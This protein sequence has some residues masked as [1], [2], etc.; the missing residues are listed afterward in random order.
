M[1]DLPPVIIY[2]VS[3]APVKAGLPPP[4]RARPTPPQA[5]PTPVR[6]WYWDASRPGWKALGR[7]EGVRIV[8]VVGWRFV[9]SAPPTQSS[10]IQFAPAGCPTGTCYGR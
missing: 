1:S 2:C 4:I 5:D 10:L 6:A 9:P 7:L 8:D 3:P